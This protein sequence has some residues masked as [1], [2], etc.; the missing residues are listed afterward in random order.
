MPLKIKY[1]TSS[2]ISRKISVAQ[3][4]RQTQKDIQAHNTNKQT[5]DTNKHQQTDTKPN[6]KENIFNFF[7]IGQYSKFVTV[8]SCPD[9]FF[10]K[11]MCG[12]LHANVSVAVK[13]TPK[14]KINF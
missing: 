12:L 8:H 7:A 10:W 3:F 6:T 1:E 4:E 11:S 9:C 14:S 2:I 13:L 5:H